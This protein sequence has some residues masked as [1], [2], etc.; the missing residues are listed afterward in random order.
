MGSYERPLRF[1]CAT[2][3]ST[4]SVRAADCSS[5][6]AAND[7]ALAAAFA[8]LASSCA[9]LDAAA[10]KNGAEKRHREC[11]CEIRARGAC[12]RRLG[13]TAWGARGSFTGGS[14]G[15]FCEAPLHPQHNAPP[16]AD[17]DTWGPK[18]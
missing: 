5:I 18:W 7:A 2:S 4:R 11:V 3:F 1:S 9:A 12:V 15:M 16:L 17:P 8:G 6:N 10:A 14:G 13:E